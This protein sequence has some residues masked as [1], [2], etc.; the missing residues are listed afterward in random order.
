MVKRS[1]KEEDKGSQ[2][3]EGRWYMIW[4]GEGEEEREECKESSRRTEWRKT[5]TMRGKKRICMS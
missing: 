1:E 4:M 3:R 5:A 2:W